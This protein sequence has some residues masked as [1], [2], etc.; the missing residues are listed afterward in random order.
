MTRLATILILASCLGCAHRSAIRKID[1][2]L[3]MQDLKA[4]LAMTNETDMRYWAS[5]AAD[6]LEASK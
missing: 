5:V 4:A 2:Q 3:A 1:R 6:E